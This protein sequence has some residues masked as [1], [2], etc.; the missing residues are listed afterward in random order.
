MKKHTTSNLSRRQS[1]RHGF[2]VAYSNQAFEYWFLL[3][4]SLLQGQLHRSRYSQMLTR[5]TGTPY[6]KTEG[7]GAAMYNRL[8]HL[9]SQAIK[10]AETVLKGISKGNPAAE[11]SSTTVH[12][13]V[14][15]LNKYLL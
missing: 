15:E 9:Q 11:E 2:R 6:S 5:L 10:N 14:T 4:F 1:L 3:H 13:L 12:L 8:L 7:F